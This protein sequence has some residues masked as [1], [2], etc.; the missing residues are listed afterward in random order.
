LPENFENIAC[1]LDEVAGVV[2]VVGAGVV[3]AGVVAVGV[4]VA[5]AVVVAAVAVGAVGEVS[6]LPH[7][8]K[9]AAASATIAAVK[10]WCLI[11]SSWDMRLRGC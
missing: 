9:P 5:G 8:M 2:G 4:V 10:G 6:D 7:A 11:L 1:V 3:G